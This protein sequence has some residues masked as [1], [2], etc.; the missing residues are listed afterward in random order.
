MNRRNFIQAVAGSTGLWALDP[1]AAAPRPTAK[2]TDKTYE[3]EKIQRL[4]DAHRPS[5]I[6]KLPRDFN[7]RV[8]ASHV[9]G[10]YHLTD[11]PYLIEGAEKLLELGSR[12]GKFWFMPHSPATKYPFNSQWESCATLL[13]LA[14]SKYFQQLFALPFSTII[15]ETDIAIH[16][17]TSDKKAT[18]VS[19]TEV[20]QAYFDLTAHFYQVFRDR[21]VTVILQNWEGDWL[22]RGRA[23]E[24]WKKPPADWKQRCEAMTNALA[25]RQKGVTEARARFGKGAKCRIAHAAE[26]N[27]VTDLWKG[28]PTMTEH[29]LPGV[30][31]DLVS[32]SCYDGMK[33]GVTL[34]KCIR[35]IKQHAR[36]T[37]LFGKNSVYVGEIGIPENDYPNRLTGRWD[38]FF[39]AMLAADVPYIVMWELYCNEANPKKQPAPPA[40]IK[41]PDDARGFWLVR[42]DGSLS[43]TGKFFSSLWQRK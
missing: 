8:G 19:L 42:P 11:K 32:Y 27:C 5:R 16:W 36:T 24:L 30:E 38:E 33:D 25:A 13:D 34:W 18:A 17:P 15:L 3:V 23:G 9:A 26:V 35:E 1:L 21:T 6:K 43:E 20:T 37:G 10:L 2:A 12:L 41:N 14:R 29:V 40:P 28:I 22:L 39:G 4:I 7:A 31:L